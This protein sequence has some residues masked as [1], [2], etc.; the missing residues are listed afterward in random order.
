[1]KTNPTRAGGRSLRRR[2]H[3]ALAMLSLLHFPRADASSVFEALDIDPA[4]MGANWNATTGFQHSPP[5]RNAPGFPGFLALDPIPYALTVLPSTP[6]E[7]RKLLDALD[8]RV[9]DGRSGERLIAALLHDAWDDRAAAIKLLESKGSRPAGTLHLVRM[10]YQNGELDR[11]GEEFKQVQSSLRPMFA[12]SP[13]P[14]LDS[15]LLHAIRPFVVRE[16]WQPLAGFLGWLQARCESVAWRHS[17]LLCRIDLALHTGTL[18]AMLAD[19]SRESAVARF[20]AERILSGKLLHE[21]ERLPEANAADL[22]WILRACRWLPEAS[23]AIEETIRAGTGGA[24]GRAE[25]F[26]RLLDARNGETGPLDPLM[27]GLLEQWLERAGEAP[28]LLRSVSDRERFA[29]IPAHALEKLSAANPDDVY[30]KLLAAQ[31]LL[32]PRTEEEIDD[33]PGAAKA[34]DLLLAVVAVGM[35]TT[36][37]AS[38]TSP[39]GFDERPGYALVPLPN[40]HPASSRGVFPDAANFGDNDHLDPARRALVLLRA[41]APAEDLAALLRSQPKHAALPWHDQA[42]YLE[43]AQLDLRFIDM[44]LA[45]DWSDERHDRSGNWLCT[46]LARID[47]SRQP[48]GDL[49]ERILKR[50]PAML[51]GSGRK[52]AG[53][54]ASHSRQA[55]NLLLGEMAPPPGPAT[56][57][58][59]GSWRQGLNQRSGELRDTVLAECESI[60]GDQPDGSGR[61]RGR[62]IRKDEVPETRKASLALSALGWFDPPGLAGLPGLVSPAEIGRNLHRP[63]GARPG[64]AA[65]GVRPEGLVFLQR[66]Y[67]ALEMIGSGA[68]GRMSD[69]QLTELGTKLRNLLPADSPLAAGYDIAV[70]AGILRFTD[71]AAVAASRTRAERLLSTCKEADFVLLRGSGALLPAKDDAW[72]ELSTL[73]GACQPLRAAAANALRMNLMS[74]HRSPDPEQAKILATLD[75]A[76]AQ[77]T[78]ERQVAIEREQTEEKPYDLLQR[79]SREGK[80][81]AEQAVALAKQVLNDFVKSGARKTTPTENV[82]ISTLAKAG[83]FDAFIRDVEQQFRHEDR[84][85]LELARAMEAL[86]GYGIV[87]SGGESA[88]FAR[89]VLKL[90]PD[91]VIAARIVGG[92]A[93]R[94]RKPDEFLDALQVVRKHDREAFFDFFNLGPGTPHPGQTRPDPLEMLETRHAP[95]L[96]EML[97]LEEKIRDGKRPGTDAFATPYGDTVARFQQFFLA[98]DPTL[99]ARFRKLVAQR[100]WGGKRPGAHQDKEDRLAEDLLAAGMLDELAGYLADRMAHPGSI[101]RGDANRLPPARQSAS[102][103]NPGTF[104]RW[105]RW[106][107][108][109]GQRQLAPRILAELAKRPTPPPADLLAI[110]NILADPTDA[111]Y[112]KH[113]HDLLSGVPNLWISNAQFNFGRILDKIPSAMALRERILMDRFD[114]GEKLQGPELEPLLEIHL[115]RRNRER[116]REVW[117]KLNDPAGGWQPAF[118][119]RLL[120]PLARNADDA[121]WSDC[122]RRIMEG[123]SP[124][125]YDLLDEIVAISGEETRPRL[126]ALF[127]QL[128]AKADTS[129]GWSGKEAPVEWVGRHAV[130]AHRLGDEESLRSLAVRLRAHSGLEDKSVR[131]DT[132]RKAQL[133]L[134]QLELVTGQAVAAFPV[135]DARHES[136]ANWSVRWSLAGWPGMPITGHQMDLSRYCFACDA[137][138]FDGRFDVIVLAGPDK[139]AL[140]EVSAVRSAPGRGSTSVSLPPDSTHLALLAVDRETKA[141][142]RTE[143]VR[144]ASLDVPPLALPQPATKPLPPP[145]PFDEDCTA[146]GIKLSPGDKH[147]LLE[148]PCS[149]HQPLAFTTWLLVEGE[150]RLGLEF[151]DSAGK[152]IPYR[153]WSGDRL[154]LLVPYQLPHWE[155]VGDESSDCRA[156]ADAARAFLVASHERGK[157]PATVWLYDPRLELGGRPELGNGETRLACLPGTTTSLATSPDGLQIAAGT[158]RGELHVFDADGRGRLAP[159]KLSAGPLVWVG[160]AGSRLLALDAGRR[161]ASFDPATGVIGELGSI[162]TRAFDASSI[163]PAL[164]PDGNWLAW[165]GPEADVF[166]ARLEADK[167]AQP[168]RL[169]AG[170][171]AAV[172]VDQAAGV[173]HATGEAGEFT[174]PLADLPG[175]DPATIKTALVPAKTPWQPCPR[176]DGEWIDP[177][178]RIRIRPNSSA[179]RF[180]AARRM[181]HVAESPHLTVSAGGIVFFTD[182]FGWLHRLDPEKMEGYR[183]PE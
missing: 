125:R 17:V 60:L 107:E 71:E 83:L 147:V 66:R 53:L 9:A 54:I 133:L 4:V 149:P 85:E 97:E 39:F 102:M 46:Y 69:P 181:L 11:A 150:A 65:N 96:L 101:A 172:R 119:S 141:G 100:Q 171:N 117:D 47:R 106:L 124:V 164:T 89:R 40:S 182:P 70:H 50:L 130:V 43:A 115:A 22:A 154:H 57:A 7:R 169:P 118:S 88:V 36:D 3:V 44:L 90:D 136:G 177:V 2:F 155:L 131:D 180:D 55:W 104:D 30:L 8:L 12:R 145:M 52:P 139:D 112:Q 95:R 19:L 64:Q 68:R 86:H 108:A 140:R 78:R 41:I 168:V 37:P 174:I 152:D 21:G 173:L 113:K 105:E 114:A 146:V 166:V 77:R 29:A 6:D 5:F 59:L 162:D 80:P 103:L 123:P 151:H 24:A 75:P 142:H 74:A 110:L 15:N 161:L 49:Q 126:I 98:A 138:A 28:G 38:E 58:C 178:H 87:H 175:L 76:G 27:I 84:G 18:D 56:K 122:C 61:Q 35:T 165:P 20:V 111:T 73:A 51:L 67:P 160:F 176:N 42:R 156:P 13:F 23:A 134:R 14:T 137:G 157:L 26:S 127:R 128:L 120:G 92:D 34:R 99:A 116:A 109:V 159:A 72:K 32:I 82:A 10:L 94:N 25:L 93:Y 33:L 45:A 170:T 79:W 132:R 48:A 183:Q 121:M 158:H 31:A 153:A 148:L 143:P 91:D 16:E 63:P 129:K 1:M 167:T 163:R 179:T 144:L 62:S 81:S 135:L